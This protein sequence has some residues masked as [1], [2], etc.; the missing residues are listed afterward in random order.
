MIGS[1]VLYYIELML[2]TSIDV[3]H[4]FVSVLIDS[5]DILKHKISLKK[6]AKDNTSAYIRTAY[7]F[8]TYDR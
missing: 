6:F 7:N 4:F 1:L 8:F 2:L 5:Q 3:V